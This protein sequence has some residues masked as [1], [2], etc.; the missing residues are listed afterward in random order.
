MTSV[1]RSRYITAWP[2]DPYTDMAMSPGTGPG[3]YKYEVGS[4]GGTYRLPVYGRDGKVI[5]DLRG[6]RGGTV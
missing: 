6:G 1:G 3:R 2:I 4:G 5:L